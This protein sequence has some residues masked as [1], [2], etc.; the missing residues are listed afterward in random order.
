[1]VTLKLNNDP[2]WICGALVFSGRQ[3]PTWLLNN[4]E[5]QRILN[6]W[7]SLPE[8]HKHISIPNILGYKGC[9]LA[10]SSIDKWISFRGIVSFYRE[11]RIIESRKD[12]ER[13]FEKELLKTAPE[14]AIPKAMLIE[15]F[16]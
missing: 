7:N 8:S 2:Y 1:M 3:D 4:D 10:S 14:E 16:K 13:K 5:A 9:F 6:I 12:T 11:G 15:E